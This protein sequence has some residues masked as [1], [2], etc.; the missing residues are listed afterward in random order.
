MAVASAV[1]NR[2][3]LALAKNSQF[4]LCRRRHASRPLAVGFGTGMTDGWCRLRSRSI[5]PDGLRTAFRCRGKRPGPG[6]RRSRWTAL[7]LPCPSRRRAFSKCRKSRARQC[8]PSL[9]PH[10]TRNKWARV[11]QTPAQAD[12]GR[13]WRSPMRAIPGKP[14]ARAP[15]GLF[16]GRVPNPACRRR[17]PGR[18]E[19]LDPRQSC[20]AAQSVTIFE[21][22]SSTTKARNSRSI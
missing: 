21:T 10:V 11:Q 5:A 18:A 19:A 4:R 2:G 1:G 13:R 14:S 16:P 7:Q 22:H 3:D 15:G 20:A 8:R 17:R 6:N 12:F 9:H